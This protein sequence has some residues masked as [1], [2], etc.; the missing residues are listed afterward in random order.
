MPCLWGI[1]RGQVWGLGMGQVVGWALRSQKAGKSSS[2]GGTLGYL[3]LNLEQSSK[4][5]GVQLGLHLPQLTRNK[6]PNRPKF[7]LSQLT[8]GDGLSRRDDLGWDDQG[9]FYRGGETGAGT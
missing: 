9:R 5:L 1:G 6:Y 3:V 7:Y 8:D 2:F 4:L